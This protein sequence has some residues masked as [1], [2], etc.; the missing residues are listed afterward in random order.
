VRKRKKT[1]EEKKEQNQENKKRRRK[2]KV[3]ENVR[4]GFIFVGRKQKRGRFGL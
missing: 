4:E 1:E 3:E 2:M